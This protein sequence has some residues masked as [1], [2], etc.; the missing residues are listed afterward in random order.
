M[1]MNTPTGTAEAI[2]HLQQGGLNPQMVEAPQAPQ[3]ITQCPA[4]SKSTGCSVC[5]GPTLHT[6]VHSPAKNADF[7]VHKCQANDRHKVTWCKTP[8]PGA[9]RTVVSGTNLVYGS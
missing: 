7:N 5:N 8:I 3:A 1:A 2:T 6:T 9:L 4:C